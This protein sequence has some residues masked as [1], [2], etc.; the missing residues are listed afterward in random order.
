[1]QEFAWRPVTLTSAREH[2]A[3]L[4]ETR[5]GFALGRRRSS[6][7]SGGGPCGRSVSA[8]TDAA[9][10]ELKHLPPNPENI[11]SEPDL[12][13]GG[14]SK[15]VTTG[16]EITAGAVCCEARISSLTHKRRVC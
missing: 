4:G 16:G 5:I 15:P 9:E 1:M 2:P 8:A 3:G 6:E 7:G 14:R 13:Q 12:R 10:H 11:G